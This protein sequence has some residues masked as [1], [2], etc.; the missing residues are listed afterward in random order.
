MAIWNI[1]L[2][3]SIILSILNI[4]RLFGIFYRL[5]V[6]I[7]VI[8]YIFLGRVYCSK[9]YRAKYNFT[10]IYTYEYYIH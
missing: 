8:W 3:L 6:Y 10:G 2:R 5:S 4:F 9:K 1:L 7:V